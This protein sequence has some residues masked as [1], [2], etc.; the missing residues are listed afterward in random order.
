[1]LK[2]FVKLTQKMKA[3][4]QT[5]YKVI[6][7]LILSPRF[8][9]E[10]FIFIFFNILAL[11]SFHFTDQPP[12]IHLLTNGHQETLPVIH[13]FTVFFSVVCLTAN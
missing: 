1:M 12:Y 5:N 4:P 3:R 2:I 8:T 10:T 9:K 11:F 13:D 7:T 6:N